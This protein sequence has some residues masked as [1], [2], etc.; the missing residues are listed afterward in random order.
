[1]QKENIYILC[2]ILSVLSYFMIIKEQYLV[3]R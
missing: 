1:M 3:Y 2:K